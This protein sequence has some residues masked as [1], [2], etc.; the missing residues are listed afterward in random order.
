RPAPALA[1]FA[2]HE[3][4]E[5]DLSHGGLD[6]VDPQLVRAAHTR[7]PD[8]FQDLDPRS[9]SEL[10]L[11]LERACTPEQIVARAHRFLRT[12]L[13]PRFRVRFA[14]LAYR[15]MLELLR[16]LEAKQFRTFVV[17]GGSVEF[18]RAAC[19]GLYGVPRERVVGPVFN[20]VYDH[21]ESQFFVTRAQT[22]LENGGEAEG[23]VRVLMQHI[24]RRPVMAVGNSDA[25]RHMLEYTQSG[26]HA[27]LCLLVQ[28]DDPVREYAYG[29]DDQLVATSVGRGWPI[30]SMRR[31]FRRI[32]SERLQSRSSPYAVPVNT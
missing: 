30:I 23:K 7:D 14:Q 19:E 20:Y 6:H 28:H 29:S 15:P 3:L 26:C 4:R 9:L 8:V 11:H 5:V 21:R 16:L 24:G 12:E 27:S 31:D 18:L 2:M 25:D 13:H 10:L 1:F 17:T 32:F 22:L